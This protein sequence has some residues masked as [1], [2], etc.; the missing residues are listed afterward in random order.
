MFL[1]LKELTGFGGNNL[2]MVCGVSFCAVLNCWKKTCIIAEYGCGFARQRME[3]K[4]KKLKWDA[5]CWH[6]I[7][8][9]GYVSFKFTSVSVLVNVFSIVNI[10]TSVNLK[11]SACGVWFEAFSTVFLAVAFI[12]FLSNT[13]NS[14]YFVDH[15]LSRFCDL[16]L[17][18]ICFKT[19]Q[20][21]FV[22]F[23]LSPLTLCFLWIG[24]HVNYSPRK[25]RLSLY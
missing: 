9:W 23:I 5:Y 19:K 16:N 6:H 20:K 15:R 8:T 24:R 3:A 7:L 10:F 12:S 11:D 22:T 2:L 4:R 14:G 21:S 18:V 25:L 13:A 17:Q 1:P